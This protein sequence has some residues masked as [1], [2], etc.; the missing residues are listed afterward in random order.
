MQLLRVSPT[1]DRPTRVE[2]PAKRFSVA[3]GTFDGDNS[4]LDSSAETV[5]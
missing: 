5:L 4:E 3:A 2:G 1:I